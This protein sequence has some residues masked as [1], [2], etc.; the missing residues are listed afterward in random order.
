MLVLAWKISTWHAP[1]HGALWLLRFGAH[2][3]RPPRI[4]FCMASPYRTLD[5]KWQCQLQLQ[6]QVEA[7]SLLAPPTPPPLRS[8]TKRVA[9]AAVF[10]GM[11]SI[12]NTHSSAAGEP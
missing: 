6:L 8:K 5:T 4:P 12:C 10:P 9:A 11:R 3:C 2:A 1:W 7:A